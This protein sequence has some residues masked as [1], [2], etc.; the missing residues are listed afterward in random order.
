M[1]VYQVDNAWLADVDVQGRRIRR[2]CTSQAEAERLERELK[3]QLLQEHHGETDRHGTLH[4]LYRQ[5]CQMDWSASPSSR[6]RAG[7]VVEWFGKQVSPAAITASAIDQWVEDRRASGSGNGTIRV[8]LSALRVMLQR[9]QRLGLI[10]QMPLLPEPRTLALPEPRDLIVEDHWVE[11]QVAAMRRL[12]SE[13]E[14]AVGQRPSRSDSQRRNVAIMAELTLFL[15]YMGCRVNE[16][17]SLRWENLDSR[18][19]VQFILTKGKRARRL[20]MFPEARAA[21]QAT[22]SLGCESCPFPIKYDTYLGIHNK[23]KALVCDALSLS[24]YIRD[25]WVIHTLRHTRLTELAQMG[26]SGAQIKEWAGHSS[27]LV[28]ERYIHGA[29]I[30]FP[31]ATN[32]P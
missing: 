14:A 28:S 29:G 18:G 6:E 30:S 11:L 1:T 12:A 23:T 19:N 27:I 20:P 32:D 16:A 8:Y 10:E 26:W 31:M 5:C 13:S 4:W 3:R 24:D 21:L 9:A 22:K 7:R 25:N 2:R 17:L 15:R